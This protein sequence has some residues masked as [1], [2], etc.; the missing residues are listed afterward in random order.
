[1]V[2]NSFAGLLHYLSRPHF[3]FFRGLAQIWRMSGFWKISCARAH[4]LLIV[5]RVTWN[6]PHWPLVCRKNLPSIPECCISNNNLE[7]ICCLSSPVSSLF[8]FFCWTRLNVGLGSGESIVASDHRNGSDRPFSQPKN[9]I[10]NI[11]MKSPVIDVIHGWTQF[12]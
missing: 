11:K 6:L 12:I 4:V 1:M 2:W 5:R 8:V 10:L 7:T 3:F 9:S